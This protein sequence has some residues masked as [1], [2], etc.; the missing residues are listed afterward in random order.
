[1]VS[2][3][4]RRYNGPQNIQ[5]TSLWES[6]HS[7]NMVAGHKR[8][9]EKVVTPQ[10]YQRSAHTIPLI[11]HKRHPSSSQ[12]FISNP[13]PQP[14]EYLSPNSEDLEGQKTKMQSVFRRVRQIQLALSRRHESLLLQG[15]ASLDAFK[16]VYERSPPWS[17]RW[18]YPIILA[19]IG[20]RCVRYH[21][22][23]RS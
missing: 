19:Q 17:A 12:S 9:V 15:V 16:P 6:C 22:L 20:V 2:G 5:G 3:E 18:T 8:T 23:C 7:R 11:R 14:G 21:L 4:N 1:M 13:L 10:T